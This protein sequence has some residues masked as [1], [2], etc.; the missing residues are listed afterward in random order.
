MRRVCLVNPPNHAFDQYDFAPP[1]GLMVLAD[2]AAD[3]GWEPLILDLGLPR[4]L[5]LADNP[6]RFYHEAMHEI[7]ASDPSVVAFTSMAVNSHVSLELARLA[8]E[9]DRRVVT[10]VGGPHFSAIQTQLMSSFPWID[11]VVLGE[12]ETGWRNLMVALSNR[13]SGMRSDRGQP[14]LISSSHH[15]APRHPHNYELVDLPGYF[16][17]NDRRVVDYE[18]GRGC[19]FKCSFCYSPGHYAEVREVDPD[20]VVGDWS[21]LAELGF[22]QVFMVQDNFTNDPRHAIRV[23]DALA[24][25]RL[26][27]R[28]N[29][30]ATLPQLTPNV[31]CALGRSGCN[32]LYLGVDAVSPAQMSILN[33]HF[34]RDD[35]RLLG[36]LKSLRDEGVTPTCAFMID[37]FDYQ[38]DDFEIVLRVAIACAALD[39][40]IRLNTLT[41]Y[42][43]SALFHAPRRKVQ[44]SDAKV[45]LMLDCPLVVCQNNFAREQPELFPFHATEIPV[46]VWTERLSMVRLAQ[47]LIQRY[48]TD[49]LD[50]ARGSNDRI[51]DGLVRLASQTDDLKSQARA[52]WQL[53]LF[54]RFEVY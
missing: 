15:S 17:A 10:V 16:A 51:V 12:G 31:I 35:E 27:L 32:A 29:G 42:P 8:K 38:P 6:E 9:R 48:H 39:I 2:V 21:R 20:Q 45:R 24:A 33:K 44:Y 41:R 13:R 7:L 14:C 37:L 46:E 19:V 54:N 47:P 49:L 50:I 26:P 4:F 36:L 34:Y 3:V 30:Y 25:A 1:L 53:D 52:G 5:H 28:W 23:C 40:P 43:G 18:G 11:H 22:K